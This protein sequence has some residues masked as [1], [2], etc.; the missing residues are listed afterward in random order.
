MKPIS[1]VFLAGAEVT[2]G[3][4]LGGLLDAASDVVAWFI[5]TMG[6]YLKFVTDNPIILMM[7]LIM[8]AGAG[9]GFLMRIWKS[10]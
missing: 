2:D 8:L 3:S 9:I 1:N 6:S 5:T 10:A 4:T 7:F